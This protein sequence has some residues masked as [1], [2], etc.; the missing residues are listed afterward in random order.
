MISEE[1]LLG[2]EGGEDICEEAKSMGGYL[3]YWDS[4]DGGQSRKA[5]AV[6]LAEHRISVVRS[7]L[8]CCINY[9]T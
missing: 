3:E 2:R 1:S 4:Q 5:V 6:F 7:R 9:P 8:V